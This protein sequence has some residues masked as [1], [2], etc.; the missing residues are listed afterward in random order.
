ME[1]G[2]LWVDWVHSLGRPFCSSRARSLQ[3]SLPP[4][5]YPKPRLYLLLPRLRKPL[6]AALAQPPSSLTVLP[7]LAAAA[8]AL[9]VPATPALP[10]SP[11]PHLPAGL[12]A[13]A[14]ALPPWPPAAVGGGGRPLRGHGRLLD[15]P[16][17]ARAAPRF[18]PSLRS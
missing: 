17:A 13:E 15:S 8:A 7:L 12:R 5:L 2:M 11:P 9:F 1:R 3:S 14:T 16:A 10:P 6:L 18:Y 4:S